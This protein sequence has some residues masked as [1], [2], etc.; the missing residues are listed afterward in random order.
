MLGEYSDW[1]GGGPASELHPAR[2]THPVAHGEDGVEAVERDRALHLAGALDLNGQG[3]LDSCRRVQ[4]P[5][6]EDVLQVQGDVLFRGVKEFRHFEL[7]Q[8][9]SL[10]LR[11]EL[12]LAASGVEDQVVHGIGM[13]GS[14]APTIFVMPRE[15]FDG[16]LR[17][18]TV[19]RPPFPPGMGK[20][21]ASDLFCGS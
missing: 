11:P 17:E 2:R 19:L 18:R 16:I 1:V 21:A 9:H 20:A 3:F 15:W 14:A 4:L 6:L 8:P 10:L 13:A 5:V 7:G 12:D